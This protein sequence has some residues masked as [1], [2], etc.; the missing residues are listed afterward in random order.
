MYSKPAK[1]FVFC[2]FIFSFFLH[3]AHAEQQTSG[4]GIYIDQDM[5]VPF[6]TR[7]VTTQW[8]SLSNFSGQKIKDFTF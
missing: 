7:T 5:F 2:S 1:T 6:Q 3:V 4:I 8:D